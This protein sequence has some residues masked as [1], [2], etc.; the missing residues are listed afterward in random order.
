MRS[1]AIWTDASVASTEVVADGIR[2]IEF[3]VARDLPPFEPGS[4]LNVEVY[5][6]G[7]PDL[8]S[9]SCLPSATAERRL[10]VAVKR[11]EDS[12][13][14]SRYM[15]SLTEGARIRLSLPENRFPL[16]YSAAHYLLIA[17]GVGIT[18]VYGMALALARRGASLR[19]L[20]AAR[21]R[22]AMAFLEELSGALG[23]KLELFASSEG[24][25]IDVAA[26]IGASPPGT[27]L[28]VCGPI[29]L[30]DDARRAWRKAGRPPDAIRF[31]VFGDSGR[32]PTESF[33]VRVAGFEG[34]VHVP[35]GQ[36]MLSALTEAGIEMIY[37]CL[38]GECGLCAVD[39]LE[40]DGPIDHR[41]V[42]FSEEE[43]QEGRK[44]CT[45]VSR[46]AG[47]SVTVDVGY[48]E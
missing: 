20:Y 14:G 5:V 32:L 15:W 7:R 44:M 28:Y 31:E 25:R 45:C 23:G 9:Y 41:D 42:F 47:G 26:E 22:E 6:R 33:E 19:L 27:E 1:Q 21:S 17:G 46:L 35:V 16:S 29:G 12:R 8:R 24:R 3:A 39:I 38:R 30:L 37:D 36:T 18:P 48:R 11:H 4:H 2:R 40:A 43:K 13:G 34:S 10:C